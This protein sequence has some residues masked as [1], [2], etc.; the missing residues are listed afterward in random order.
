MKHI[1]KGGETMTPKERVIAEI[2]HKET[3]FIPYA[4]GFDEAGE[5]VERVNSYYGGNF[6]QDKIDNHIVHIP[7]AHFGIDL[8][9]E[10]TFST[11]MYGTLWRVDKRPFHL[12]KPAL[13]K[14]T[15]SGYEFPGIEAF[16]EQAGV[17]IWKKGKEKMV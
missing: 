15:L 7:V 3:D 5:V 11:D 4:L 17:D 12:E 6:W 8:E 9:S 14:P 2:K 13:N 1:S 10:K 16:L